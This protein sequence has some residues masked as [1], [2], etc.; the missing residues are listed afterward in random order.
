MKIRTQLI[1]SHTVLT[2]IAILILAIPAYIMQKKIV[3]REITQNTELQIEKVN[4][5]I[6]NFIVTIQ[7][8]KNTTI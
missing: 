1:I 7:H 3:Q 4:S 6:S 2:A 8:N 5:D